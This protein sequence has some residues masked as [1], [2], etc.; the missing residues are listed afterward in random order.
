MM[1]AL[2]GLARPN[3]P[4]PDVGLRP[5][6]ISPSPL[7]GEGRGEGSTATSRPPSAAIRIV[8]IAATVVGLT[9]PAFAADGP[10][11]FNVPARAKQLATP[12]FARIKDACLAVADD[13]NW[14]KLKPISGLK[15]TEDYGSDQSAEDFAWA[16]MVLAGRA[17]AGDQ[18]AAGDAR[19][20][21][22]RF[23]AAKSFADTEV[24]HDAYFALKRTLLPTIVTYAIVRDGY[25]APTRQAV[26]A[27][28]DPLVRAVDKKFDGD[29]DINNHRYLADAVLTVWGSLTGDAALYAH[30][31]ER[32]RAAL[33]AAR[34]DGGLPLEVR[35]GSRALW[36]QR[37]ALTDLTVIA[38][39]AAAHGEDLYGLAVDGRSYDRLLGYL[40]SGLNAPALVRATASA[41]YIPGPADD[42]LAQDLGFLERRG[43]DRHFMAFAEPLVARG[44]S[45]LARQRLS[46]VMASGPQNE[47]PLIDEF[48]GG[49]ATCF[50]G[51]P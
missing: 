18:A 1:R 21:L 43:N 3:S 34:E 2:C 47:R 30:G 10:G 41:N 8:A 33:N 37:L 6:R 51:R 4:S 42:Y 11:L 16:V 26:E 38:E 19:A 20:L 40:M 29:V 50:W 5:R 45:S 31:A 7:A 24:E 12:E 35:R 9:L 27:W 49:N 32:Y 44:G 28:L 15:A 46:I 22:A 36:Y 25:D 48:M 13:P 23:A 39:T 17:L 14:A